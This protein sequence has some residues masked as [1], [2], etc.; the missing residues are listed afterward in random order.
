MTFSPEG[1]ARIREG[2]RKR[3]A[4]E[5]RQKK[6]K[7]PSKVIPTVDYSALFD[8]MGISDDPTALRSLGVAALQRSVDVE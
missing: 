1:L 4:L 6:A 5:K 7:P 3:R 2:Q 8:L